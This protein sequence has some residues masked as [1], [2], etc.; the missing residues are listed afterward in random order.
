MRLN[1]I[2]GLGICKI[3][4]TGTVIQSKTKGDLNP[5]CLNFVVDKDSLPT[6]KR[7]SATS[8]S[9]SGTREL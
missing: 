4:T 5:I 6:N 3:E 7:N 2:I 9:E 8:A 1:S